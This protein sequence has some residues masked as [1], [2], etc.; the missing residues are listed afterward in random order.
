M[1]CRHVV[2]SQLS[3]AR[4]SRIHRT[5]TRPFLHHPY[6]KQPCLMLVTMFAACPLLQVRATCT[7]TGVRRTKRYRA[8]SAVRVAACEADTAAD[9]GPDENGNPDECVEDDV[10]IG[11]A[12]M[13]T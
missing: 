8:H 6:D 12:H 3:L 10:G 5:H 1:W 2:S 9:S 7:V 11:R 13:P 4:L